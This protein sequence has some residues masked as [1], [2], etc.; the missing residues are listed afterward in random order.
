MKLITQLEA[1]VRGIVGGGISFDT[2][3]KSVCDEF[4]G[5]IKG[6]PA[7]VSPLTGNLELLRRICET[8]DDEGIR[9]NKEVVELVLAGTVE[10]GKFLKLPD[11]NET[12]EKLEVIDR[13]ITGRYSVLFSLK[14]EKGE[15]LTREFFD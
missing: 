4:F 6:L 15:R 5:W 13:Q 9:Q 8:F 12:D 1:V 3:W 14:T 10:P 7:S 11:K 2:K